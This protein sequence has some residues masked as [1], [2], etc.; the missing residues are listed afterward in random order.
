VNAAE[1]PADRDD[2]VEWLYENWAKIDAWLVLGT[3]PAKR[4][5]TA[6]ATP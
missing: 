4:P 1:I 5:T 6:Q 3:E 2:Q